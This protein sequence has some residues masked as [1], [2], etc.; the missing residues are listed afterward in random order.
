MAPA[1]THPRTDYDHTTWY[2]PGDRLDTK[3]KRHNYKG[4]R[5]VFCGGILGPDLNKPEAEQVGKFGAFWVRESYVVK[6]S[7]KNKRDYHISFNA[8]SYE[9]WVR[10]VASW[11]QAQ[12]FKCLWTMD[13]VSY[14]QRKLAKQ[15]KRKTRKAVI[16][17]CC[18]RAGLLTPDQQT[19]QFISSHTQSFFYDLWNTY[20][21]D[22]CCDVETILASYGHRLVF[23]PPYYSDL[24]PIET[25]WA[26]VKRKVA[27]EYTTETT[28]EEVLE[29]LDRALLGLT[30]KQVNG[31]F[32]HAQL[33]ETKLRARLAAAEAAIEDDKA[34]AE[35][36]VEREEQAAAAQVQVLVDVGAIGAPVPVV[37]ATPTR[38]SKRVRVA[39]LPGAV[40][41]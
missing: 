37:A 8:D 1:S 14:H 13:N 33:Y 32:K 6:P 3:K 41:F 2:Q 35:A 20:A 26:V 36:A 7:D 16:V 38:R 17:K 19:P 5:H 12:G 31:C 28:I 23:T 24:Q 40:N 9:A 29:R 4:Q 15:I 18:T 25:I 21:N 34:G 10:R 30:H 11:H 39:R 27:A 22:S